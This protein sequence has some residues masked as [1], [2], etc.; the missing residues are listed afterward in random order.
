[1]LSRLLQ[2]LK[3]L[4]LSS[5]T[6]LFIFASATTLSGLPDL[7][8]S[9]LLLFCSVATSPSSTP[10]PACPSPAVAG[11][12]L[13]TSWLRNFQATVTQQSA[14]RARKRAADR[15][16]HACFR[17]CA[18]ESSALADS[19]KTQKN[20]SSSKHLVHDTVY[21]VKRNSNKAG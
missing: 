20:S 2:L 4:R 6:C 19:K 10:P 17:P 5:E 13:V 12:S 3:L 18:P 7:V 21:Q 8:R 9:P 15:P 16:T 14:K 1:M 11:L